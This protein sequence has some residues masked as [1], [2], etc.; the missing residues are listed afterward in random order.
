MLSIFSLA[1]IGIGIAK[2][3][4]TEY[5]YTTRSMIT[6][7]RKNRKYGSYFE[8]KKYIYIYEHKMI[9]KKPTKNI[10]WILAPMPGSAEGWSNDL[11]W[12]GNHTLQTS[13]SHQLRH[14]TTHTPLWHW[15]FRLQSQLRRIIPQLIVD[16]PRGTSKEKI[17]VYCNFNVI[18]M[19]SKN[20]IRGPSHKLGKV[21]L[22]DVSRIF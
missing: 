11:F 13:I 14:H 16:Q 20:M 22:R 17:Q 9:N 15:A 21:K 19:E 1:E 7:D 2:R 10:I 8:N 18:F 12:G 3:H 6:E 4:N 5:T